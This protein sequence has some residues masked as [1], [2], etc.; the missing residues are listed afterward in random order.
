MDLG[1]L[2]TCKS[3]TLTPSGECKWENPFLDEAESI[4]SSAVS[5]QQSVRKSGVPQN[6]KEVEALKFPGFLQATAALSENTIQ[7]S[8][9]ATSIHSNAMEQSD[10]VHVGDFHNKPIVA[11][12]L[13]G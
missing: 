6:E 1:S 4:R 7:S 8:S 3:P 13:M 9:S 12:V 2:I 10:T 5:P 11:T